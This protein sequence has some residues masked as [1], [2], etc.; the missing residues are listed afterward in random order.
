MKGVR[1]LEPDY[2]IPTTIPYLSFSVRNRFK[3]ESGINDHS[4]DI[5]FA[6]QK[7][8]ELEQI[9]L[10][11]YPNNVMIDKIGGVGYVEDSFNP[12]EGEFEGWAGSK[13][14]STLIPEGLYTFEIK[15]KGLPVFEGWFLMSGL[16][17]IQSPKVNKPNLDQEYL[18]H[19]PNF[20]WSDFVTSEHQSRP[21]E[22]RKV[23]AAVTNKNGDDIA[24]FETNGVTEQIAVS[25]PIASGS[26]TFRVA[27]KERHYFGSLSL[28]RKSDTLVPFKIK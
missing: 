12:N 19:Q 27:Y 14:Q 26:Y 18:T 6:H 28:V 2:Q 20:T 10:I 22:T 7:G 3:L 25:T 5:S 13:K 16:N 17:S 15:L 8:T 21:Y 24:T 11:Q 4:M 1:A 9:R 23:S